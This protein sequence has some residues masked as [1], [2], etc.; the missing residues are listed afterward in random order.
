MMMMM[1][2]IIII[3]IIRRTGASISTI[4]NNRSWLLWVS[5]ASGETPRM[6]LLR[7]RILLESH[8]KRNHPKSF[9]ESGPCAW[10]EYALP[11][12]AVF[13]RIEPLVIPQFHDF[14]GKS[15]L[16]QGFK[17]WI[18]FSSCMF[19]SPSSRYA[20]IP[21]ECLFWFTIFTGHLGRGLKIPAKQWRNGRHGKC[22][23]VKQ[24]LATSHIYHIYRLVFWWLNRLNRLESHFLVAKT[25]HVDQFCLYNQIN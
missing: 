13:K 22:N 6:R 5:R 4:V 12:P 14:G 9:Q 24:S 20:Y 2:M 10:A 11:A 8:D 18:L 25:T 23:N 17:H 15:S 21:F 1:M 19:I 3:I 7:L 16:Y